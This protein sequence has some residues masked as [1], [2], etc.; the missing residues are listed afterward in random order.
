VDFIKEPHYGDA[1]RR[2]GRPTGLG[3]APV[4]SAGPARMSALAAAASVP[5]T[6]RRIRWPIFGFLFAFSVIAYVQRTSVAVAADPMMSELGITQ[7]QVGW[8]LTAFLVSYT[9]FQF[10]GSVLGQRAGARWALFALGALAFIATFGTSAAPLLL[11]GTALM[12][13]LLAAR[14]V[15]GIAQAPLFPVLS[16]GIEAW[17]PVRQWA[18]VQGILAGALNLGSAVTPPLIANLM[19]VYGWKFALVATSVP[20]LALIVWWAWY[21]RDNPRDHPGVGPAELA[22]LEGNP[23]VGTD[24]ALSFARILRMLA[25]PDLLLLSGSYLLMNYVFYLL[26]FW[27]FLYLVQERHFAVLESG[28]LAALPFVAAAI[29]SV[30]GGAINERLCARHGA[31]WGFRIAP[32]AALALSGVFLLLVA[33]SPN[34]VC[35]VVALCGAFAF[36]ELTEASYWAATMRVCP[37][38]TMA[39]TGIL[40]TGGNIGGII[41]T[42]IVAALSANGHWGLTFVTGT[43]F[44]LASAVLWFWVDVT[45]NEKPHEA[46]APAT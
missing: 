35:A 42:P 9:V 5:A 15:L 38:D 39:A 33:V 46:L 31:R 11:T 24:N 14:F 10:P 17:F 19:Q 32:L 26:T 44:A 30:L 13:A 2:H 22:E 16:G 12:A 34:A 8:L 4:P 7:V 3:A 23:P 18:L 37:S 45:R 43:G 27:C 36:V 28:W 6:T 40:N 41:A 20:G 29:G 1:R 21:A 25:N